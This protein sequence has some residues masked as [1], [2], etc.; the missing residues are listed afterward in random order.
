M[1]KTKTFIIEYREKRE[2]KTVEIKID[3]VSNWV[4]RRF[5]ELVKM[6]T[7]AKKTQDRLRVLMSDKGS[8]LLDGKNKVEGWKDKIKDLEKEEKELKTILDGYKEDEHFNIM[9]EIVKDILD[10]NGVKEDFLY[11]FNFWDRN[12]TPQDMMSFIAKAV[13][14]DVGDSEQKQGGTPKK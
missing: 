12:V 7:D 10:F 1:N 8:V 3:A 4:D 14:K 13:Y 5:K 6:G 9:F 11:E 2:K